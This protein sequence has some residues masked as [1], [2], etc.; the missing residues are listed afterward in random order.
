MSNSKLLLTIS[1]KLVPS[2]KALYSS[3]ELALILVAPALRLSPVP[4][5]AAVPTFITDFAI[6]YT[7]SNVMFVASNVLSKLSNVFIPLDGAVDVSATIAGGDSFTDKN[8]QSDYQRYIRGNSK[9][10]TNHLIT[11]HTEQT[12]SIIGMIPDGGKIK[13]LP[14]EYWEIRKFNKAFQRMPSGGV[15]ATVDTGHRN[16]FHYKQNRIPSVRENARLQSFK[17]DW[18]PLGSKTSQYKQIG[19]A[20]PPLLAENVARTLKKYL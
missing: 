17:D 15:S 6:L 16:Y 14:R 18:E 19:N 12:K 7:L 3:S 8:Y 1:F 20:V 4:S 9:Q 10:I 5:F 2:P 13:D 11:M